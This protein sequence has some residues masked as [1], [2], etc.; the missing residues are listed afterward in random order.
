MRLHQRDDPGGNLRRQSA[1]RTGAI[2]HSFRLTAGLA[3]AKDFLHV[4][5]AHAKHRRQCSEAAMTLRMRLKDLAPQI[6]L[7]GSR[8]PGLRRRVSPPLH[9]TICNIALISGL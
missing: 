9:Y 8:H 6:I 4:P 7:I 3:L 1:L 5:Q 2:V